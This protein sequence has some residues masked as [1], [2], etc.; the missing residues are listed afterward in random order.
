MKTTTL[1]FLL[2]TPLFHDSFGQNGDTVRLS[3]SDFPFKSNSLSFNAD[4]SGSL[5]VTIDNIDSLNLGNISSWKFFEKSNPEPIQE[6][7]ADVS[8]GIAKF[9][10]SDLNGILI[11]QSLNLQIR[12]DLSKIIDGLKV[13]ADTLLWEFIVNKI[14]SSDTTT[15]PEV[16][17]TS[18]DDENAK[19]LTKAYLDK[20]TELY[21]KFEQGKIFREDNTIFLFIGED[22]SRI[23]GTEF[24][25]C[26]IPNVTYIIQYLSTKK[27]SKV[28]FRGEPKRGPDIVINKAQSGTSSIEIT[29]YTSQPFGPFEEGADFFIQVDSRP[30]KNFSFNSCSQAYH[31]TISAGFFGSSL[32]NPENITQKAKD[33]TL[34]ADNQTSQ[35]ALT[36]MAMFYP[37][38]RDPF[39]KYKELDFWQK[40]SFSFGTKLSEN[41]FDDFLLGL[42]FEFSKGGNFTGGIHYGQHR[43]IRGYKKFRFGKDTYDGTFDNTQTNLRWDLG[44]FLGITLDLRIVNALRSNGQDQ[45]KRATASTDQNN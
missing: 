13:T 24:P 1:I 17:S 10:L 3:F 5:T 36:I 12:G 31:V 45:K 44:I 23:P 21:P 38:P 35:K 40:W 11:D 34:Y 29:P 37:I 22:L 2:L 30:V 43:V 33:E 39:Y 41:L 27:D 14:E 8:N 20:I 19:S 18:N 42:N 28:S 32:N 26:I 4:S 9:K 15:A 16:E 6:I 7:S 25:D